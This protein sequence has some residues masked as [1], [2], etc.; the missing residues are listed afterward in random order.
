MNS[1]IQQC[2][3][4]ILLTYC[5]SCLM[6][7]VVIYVLPK[8]NQQSS[9]LRNLPLI[10]LFGFLHSGHIAID[11]WLYRYATDSSILQWLNLGLTLTS[12]LSLI[13][14]G[15]RVF[16]D[17]ND[18]VL[19]SIPLVYGFVGSA[20]LLLVMFDNTVITGLA[21]ASRLLIGLPGA[22]ITGLAMLSYASREHYSELKVY[23]KMAGGCFL[24]YGFTVV[25][26]PNSDSKFKPIFFSR[27]EFLDIFSVPV[28]L[29]QTFS[30]LIIAILL[31]YA[32]RRLNLHSR[33]TELKAIAEMSDFNNLLEHSVRQ[34][35]E[36]LELIT[37]QLQ[38]YIVEREKIESALRE[39]EFLFHAQF[40]SG[41]IGIAITSPEKGWLRV[42]PKLC[43]MLGYSEAELTGLTWSEMTYPPDL[44]L[45]LLLFQRI[46]NGEIDNYQ[47]DKRF[48]RKDGDII[49]THLTVACY[50][51]A[52]KVEFVI[53]GLLDITERKKTEA[54]KEQFFKFFNFA[55]DLQCIAGS[56]G[57]FKQ[58]N[59]AFSEVLGYSKDELLKT[60]FL[61]LIA[62]EDRPATLKEV[63]KQSNDNQMTID[64]E[65][66]Y[67]RKDGS[68][69]WLSWKSFFNPADQLIYAVARDVTES[70]KNEE[71]LQ[72][73]EMVF[74][75]TMEGILVTDEN[76]KIIATNPAFTEITGYSEAEVLGENPGVFKSGQH[77]RLFYQAMWE[78]INAV[79]N[80]QGEMWDR[81]KNG[82]LHAKFLSIKTIRNK[83]GRVHRYLGLF[84]DVTTRKRYEEEIQ[85][86]SD[87]ELNKAKLEAEKA[88]RAKSDF[89]SSMSHE[90]RTPMNAVLGFAQ[91]L[92][93]EDLTEDQLDSVNEIITAGHHLMDLINEVLDLAKIE[94]DKL[95]IRLEKIELTAL[96]ETCL[97]LIQP[98]AA[99]Y[100]V[101]VINKIG[102]DSNFCLMADR[103]R[104]K[105]VLLNLLSNAIKYN[106]T[107]GSVMLSCELMSPQT[108]RFSVTDTGYGLS[109]EQ[110]AKL[111]QPFERLNAKN[112]N[113][114][115]T[116]I[117]LLISKK[118]LEAMNG[119]MG[120]ESTEGVG[121]CF[122]VEI[123]LVL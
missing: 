87:S 90:L 86:L 30:I 55:R 29:V 93:T 10:A 80:W 98:L 34:K 89:L 118:L 103:L 117:G 20:I 91:L 96:L 32:V 82:E 44:E 107:G 108:L 15:R 5:F 70:K 40:E 61:E 19:S 14:F 111:F 36:K 16:H 102:E 49:Y 101:K 45:D 79:G 12:Y 56:D 58:V 59:P 6:L 109:G 121:S 3:E 84:S 50:R 76:N 17:R 21:V 9:L 115:G 99:R 110:I 85:R 57:F 64:F 51:E 78:S 94:S 72:L 42:N 66:R 7:G 23:L 69:C 123:P 114:E 38:Q 112:S 54:E 13:V 24:V 22:L 52:G 41:N 53:A 122:W 68:I 62:P 104:L 105:Q 81:R 71:K 75:N 97:S 77:D 1:L 18:V 2:F 92:E 113:I 116:G 65:N 48:I 60:P 106:R 74:Q 11:W 83:E 39:R 25:I 37:Q 47:L 33:Q 63:S 67:I 88:N 8:D 27:S 120:I 46:L 73:A 95:E 28:Q 119:K 43:Q 4:I 31:T 100:Q 35:T 26:L